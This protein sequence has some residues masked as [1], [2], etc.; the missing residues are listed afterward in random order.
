MY[1]LEHLIPS[2]ALAGLFSLLGAPVSGQPAAPQTAPAP[3][4]TAA[5]SA[6]PEQ[7]L[8]AVEERGRLL[9]DYFEALAQSEARLRGESDIA[10]PDAAVVIKSSDGLR[11][12]FLKDV[13]QSGGRKGTMEIAESAYDPTSR[14]AIGLSSFAPPTPAPASVISFMR[15]LQQAKDGAA[16]RKEAKPPFDHAVIREKDGSFSVYL[17]ARDAD[18]P[19]GDLLALIA[20]TGRQLVDVQA[21]HLAV[22]HLPPGEHKPGQATLHSHTDT[23]SELPSPT[24]VAL[25]IRRPDL[26]PH[27]VLTPRWMFRIDA[28]GGLTYLGPNPVPR[29]PAPSAPGGGGRR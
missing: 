29:P 6:P 3:A 26:A 15:A 10:P 25:I 20:A 4:A 19:G 1:R 7:S 22:T 8:R 17:R 9:A 2:A 24:D 21:L 5:P 27:L 12:I 18:G 14:K 28:E 11:V 16:G 13:V 23:E